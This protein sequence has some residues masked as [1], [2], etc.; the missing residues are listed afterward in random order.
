MNP[1]PNI[2]EYDITTDADGI[3]KLTGAHPLMRHKS[4][5]SKGLVAAYYDARTR[6]VTFQLGQGET[7]TDRI[8]L[9]TRMSERE[10]REMIRQIHDNPHA[11]N[12]ILGFEEGAEDEIDDSWWTGVVEEEIDVDLDA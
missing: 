12:A 10:V 4:K 11:A 9:R 7:R 2:D 6:L 3:D 1:T 8:H 5:L